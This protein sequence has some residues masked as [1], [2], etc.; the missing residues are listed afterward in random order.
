MFTAQRGDRS[1]VEDLVIIF[2]DGGSDNHEATISE[3]LKLKA[4]VSKLFLYF[5]IIYLYTLFTNY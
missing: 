5:I 1:G 3:A 2:T 4:R